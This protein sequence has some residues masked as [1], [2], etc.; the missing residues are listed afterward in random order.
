MMTSSARPALDILITSSFVIAAVVPLCRANAAL[1]DEG[2]AATAWTPR[3]T[4]KAT[5]PAHTP[6]ERPL[7]RLRWMNRDSTKDGAMARSSCRLQGS[8]LGSALLN[9]SSDFPRF[10][11]ERAT[12]LILQS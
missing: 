2:G 5:R 4:T 10:S 1:V 9:Q 3:L 6:I 7:F 8:V 12:S 11:S